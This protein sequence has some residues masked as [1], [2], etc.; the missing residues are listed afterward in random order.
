MKKTLVDISAAHRAKLAAEIR[1]RRERAGITWQ[2]MAD[3]CGVSL[4]TVQKWGSGLRTPEK[5]HLAA[6]D[7]LFSASKKC[8][9]NILPP[10]ATDY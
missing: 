2:A 1:K 9:K 6:L 4:A 5:Q 10:D 7:E 3:H 8:P